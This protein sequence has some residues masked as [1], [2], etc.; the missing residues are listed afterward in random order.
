MLSVHF[1]WAEA[2][3]TVSPITST[4]VVGN[5]YT[6]NVNVDGIANLMAS[7]VRLDFS[8]NEMQYSVGVANGGFFSGT[9]FFESMPAPGPSVDSVVVDQAVIGSGTL[10]GS[11][12]LFT[13]QF[14]AISAGSR[15]INI[16]VRM[17]DQFNQTITTTTTAATVSIEN[18]FP[19]TTSISPTSATA[20]DPDLLLT[21]N[22]TGFVSAVSIVK[23]DG[24]PLATSFVNSARLTATIPAASL[25]TAGPKSIT[26]FS[27]TP[28]GGTSNAQTFT[29]NPATLNH[30]LIDPI[31][32][33]QTAGNSFNIAITA[34]DAY[35]NTVTSFGGTVGLSTTAGAISPTTSGLFISGVR[36][37]GV[38]VTL[39]GT[40]KT[41][42]VDDG[43][44][45]TGTSGTFN[46]V[47]GTAAKVRV[48]T[49]AD[50]SGSVVAAQ[51]VASGGTVTGYAIARDDWNNFVANVAAIWALVNKMEGVVDG[52][53][54]PAGGGTSAVFTAHAIGAGQMEATSGVLVKTPSGV[55]TV[56]AGTATSVLVETAA[57]GSGSVVSARTVT[58][59]GTVT[60]YAITRD[61]SNNFVANVAAT[62]ALINKLGGVNDGDLVLAS[63]NKSAVFTG[64]VIGS[65]QMEAT[66]GVLTKA[67]SGV[68]TVTYGSLSTFAVEAGPGLA[69]IG[70]QAQGVPF[71]IMVAAKDASGNTVGS[72]NET[73]DVSSSG[74]LSNGGGITP[75]LVNGG[76]AS[77]SVTITSIGSTTIT[78]TRTSGGGQSGTSDPFNVAPS[79]FVIHAT[80]GA[81]GTI[82]PSGD[83]TAGYGTAPSFTMT[84]DENYH[85]AD[86]KVDGVSVGA[87]GSYTFTAVTADHAIAVSFAP[88]LSYTLTGIDSLSMD[89]DGDGTVDMTM[90]FKTMPYGTWY[91]N[92]SLYFG[93]PSGQ[94]AGSDGSLACYLQIATDMPPHSFSVNVK[95]NMTGVTGFGGTTNVVYYRDTAPT[96]WVLTPCR[97]TDSE[98]PWIGAPTL[99][100]TTDHF[101]NFTMFNAPS[102]NLYLSTSG[103]A[104]TGTIYQNT[105]WDQTGVVPPEDWNW[106]GAQAISFYLVPQPG[107]I[108]NVGD[109]MLEWD[110]SVVHYNSV[111][112]TGIAFDAAHTAITVG[113]NKLQIHVVNSNDITAGSYIAKLNFILVEPGHSALAVIQSDFSKLTPTPGPSYLIPY[114]GEIKAYLGD[115]ASVGGAATGDGKVDF[116]DLSL[117]TL[118]YW[119]RVPGY[120]GPD[121]YKRKYDFGP[122]EDHYVFTLPVPDNKIEFE[123]LVIFSISYG[124]FHSGQLPKV[125]APSKDPVEVALGKAVVV[126]NETRIP[127]M[128]AGA[129]TDIRAMK[130]EVEG[131]FESYCGAEKGDLLNAYDTP[132]MVMSRAEGRKVFVDIAVMGLNTHG[133]DRSGEL[134]WLRFTGRP[135]VRLT[136]G[137]ARNSLNV[138]LNVV[139]QRGEG[140]TVPTSYALQQNY[141]N[142][143][144]PATTIE[145]QI[146]VTGQVTLEVYNILG[147]RMATLVNDIQEAG[148]YQV[149]WDG[150][151][152]NHNL[153]ATGI[154]L[155][156]VKAGEFSSVKKM[157][158]VK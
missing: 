140:E 121:N 154:Y 13:L 24:S 42:S 98:Q 142:P 127:L 79:N 113:T 150:R 83:V 82:N 51:S 115:V 148:F 91:V 131:S 38:T 41:I 71:N 95:R 52:D 77:H 99:A 33:P 34:Q 125:A 19:T 116:Q 101:T 48:E 118:S 14:T 126:G 114:Q 4:W 76:L 10:S 132:V 102:G 31:S 134:V 65:A 153:V 32:S 58:S 39:A 43:F 30:F 49:A 46:V 2:S 69:P 129:V 151:N 27:P 141:P 104:A 12:I 22:G 75:P 133:I 47:A 136:S 149:V 73:V 36:T 68:L 70:Q 147:A 157:L 60:G 143:F 72:F 1:V 105:T 16:A 26:V 100:F 20:G 3:V 15:T 135:L 23:F 74:T 92:A 84:G 109:V 35:N 87:V 128:L 9:D 156:R 78:A 66:S 17:R 85:V 145:Y 110:S 146:P 120:T 40:S 94:P 6:V 122:T 89:T 25:T 8:H 67:P 117:W 54:V 80:A 158:L 107:S 28:G 86:V 55:L 137:D 5:T 97:Y 111:E 103:A 90:K 29:V 11:G 112:W 63:D 96:G 45:H 62:W 64:H 18:P 61:A 57:D 130:I 93:T 108:F 7:H 37:D 123:D 139:R 56:T 144:N 44:S 59:G 119:S 152:E 106:S 81:H 88:T 155:Y 124:Q 138:V 21:V 53:L 50:G